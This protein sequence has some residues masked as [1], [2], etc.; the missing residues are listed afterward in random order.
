MA[1]DWDKIIFS[2][3]KKFNLD[4]PDGF[5]S[6]WHDLKK[7]PLHFSKRNFGG[8]R[9]MVWGAFSSAVIVVRTVDVVVGS[10][11][12]DFAVVAGSTVVDVVVVGSVV[13]TVVV[14]ASSVVVVAS[15]VVVVSEV[16][17]SAGTVIFGMLHGPSRTGAGT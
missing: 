17:V 2:D 4:G 12:V 9:L 5:N 13:V 3:E 6:Y 7:D 1:T 14:V 15:V 16:V 11:V 8:G 10:T